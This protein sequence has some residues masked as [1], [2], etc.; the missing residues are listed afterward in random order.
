MRFQVVFRSVV[1]VAALVGF[2]ACA[3][4]P[5]SPAAAVAPAPKPTKTPM[6]DQ[7][8]YRWLHSSPCAPPCWEGIVPGKTT[9]TQAAAILR[10][11]PL[12]EDIKATQN[13]LFP[14]EG[15]VNWQWYPGIARGRALY[16]TET[17]VIY[18]IAPG[19]PHDFTLGEVITSFGDPDFVD[20][21]AGHGPDIGSGVTYSLAFI[22]ESKGFDIGANAYSAKPRITAQT[23]VSSPSFFDPVNERV[24]SPSPSEQPFL[25][26]WNG[27]REY[28]YYCRDAD[29]G[30]QRPC[31]T[32]TINPYR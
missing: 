5:T 2:T 17:Q 10:T 26:P 28:F 27:Y 15:E 25:L 1:A 32:P 16:K 8:W 13:P 14:S 9:A 3:V 29:Y 30:G 6:P 12:A 24:G 22:Y 23:I 21:R 7:Y 18:V 20:A 19:I 11:L 4:P 31:P